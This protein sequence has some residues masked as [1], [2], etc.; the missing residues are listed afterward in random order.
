MK[1]Y[2]RVTPIEIGTMRALFILKK[3]IKFIAG[4]MKRDRKTVRDKLGLGVLPQPLRTRTTRV[5]TRRRS[6]VFK[7]ADQVT[8]EMVTWKV[9]EGQKREKTRRRLHQFP[10]YATARAIREKL[11]TA[12]GIN[13]TAW[14]VNH[15]LKMGGFSWRKRKQVVIMDPDLWPIRLRFASALLLILV[16]LSLA[17]ADECAI[18]MAV[19]S[20]CVFHY[21]RRGKPP[22][23]R[24]VGRASGIAEKCHIWAMIG[25]G[26]FRKIIL[27][28]E[29]VNARVYCEECLAAVLAY[30]K[31][32]RHVLVHD[33]AGAH[34]GHSTATWAEEH[35]FPILPNFPPHSPDLNVI[36][37]LW[38][39]LKRAVAARHPTIR[40]FR[41]IVIEEFGK[42]DQAVIDKILGSFEGKLKTCVKRKG[43]H[44]DV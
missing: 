16:R 43:R 26:G 36:E 4:Q 9:Y 32:G 25:P 3:S 44:F 22:L 42:I 10:V 29:N 31:R 30:M 40:N 17:F 12:H 23:P 1:S 35:S 33:N 24:Q 8:S 14:T 13:A 38:P 6:I 37:Q 18:S 2:R 21:R 41:Q 28:D 15:D 27:F 11:R 39:H 5:S 34:A 19:D 20:T 7:L